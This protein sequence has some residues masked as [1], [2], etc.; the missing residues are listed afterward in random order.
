M[1]CTFGEV[2]SVALF[3][4]NQC[5]NYS[6]IDG[7]LHSLL[8][9]D[10]MICCTVVINLTLLSVHFLGACSTFVSQWSLYVVAYDMWFTA[11][12]SVRFVWQ[13]HC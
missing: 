4:H 5:I 8:T 10:L 6:H 2:L 1:Y 3:S 9:L 11:I 13:D 7:S 12:S